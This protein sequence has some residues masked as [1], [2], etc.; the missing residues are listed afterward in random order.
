MSKINKIS[1]SYNEDIILKK[2]GTP[3][4]EEL[5]L[6]DS[7]ISPFRPIHYL[8]SKLR[9]VSK[10]AEIINRVDQKGGTVCDL[11]AGSGTVANY[12]AHFRPVVSVDIQEYSRVLCSALLLQP[13]KKFFRNLDFK[14]LDKSERFQKL[15]WALSPLIGYE[16]TCLAISSKNDSLPLCELIEKGSII[17][18]EQGFS[19]DC[20]D[21]L[22]KKLNTVNTRLSKLNF[23]NGPE[24]LITRY[25]GGLYFSYA[26]AVQ[27]D[28]L[29]EFV[30]SA[31]EELHDTLL[32]AVLSTTSDAVNTVGKQFAQPIRPRDSSGKPKVNIHK[33]ISKGR[34]I[35]IFRTFNLW[36]ERYISLPTPKYVNHA[37]RM[38]YSE[39]LDSLGGK[40]SIIYADPPYTRDHY[41]R[42]YHVLETICLRDN[43]DIAQI[44]V[45]GKKNITRGIYREERHQS[46]FCIKSKAPAAFDNLFQKA[47]NSGS[48][49]VLSYSPYDTTKKSHPRLVTINQLKEMALKYYKKVSIESL[50]NFSHSK[51]NKTEINFDINYDAELVIICEL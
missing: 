51:L 20:S 29:L 40:V 19:S 13:E 18:F 11:F 50:G 7:D 24:A 33:R 6:L 23:L 43:P 16:E 37:Y 31:S 48:N 44:S 30:S 32:A 10:I 12:L 41:S 26:Q 39:A 22:Y 2:W 9:V 36:L 1:T 45:N 35:D 49:L 17:G 38:D 47:K 34:D 15:Y 4:L 28:V 8:G 14:I 21:D 46:P 27:L 25:Y 5:T 3:D 42:F